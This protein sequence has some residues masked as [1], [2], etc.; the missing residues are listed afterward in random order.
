M[1]K[2]LALSI[3][4]AMLFAL[5]TIFASHQPA[6][7]ETFTVTNT[8]DSGPGSLRQAI[9]DANS[10]SNAVIDVINFSIGTGVKTISPLS[11]LPTILQSVII[12]GTTQP[13]YAGTPIIEIEG[14]SAGAGPGLSISGSSGTVADG[15]TIKGLVINRFNG[16][17]IRVDNTNSVIIEDNY[18]GTDVTGSI[19]LGN[20]GSGIASQ[21][22]VGQYIIRRN[23][24]S[25]NG[26]N[27]IFLR[28]FG[29]TI[30]DN[31]IGTDATG[32]FAIGNALNGINAG[33]QAVT[34]RRN[35]ISGNGQNGVL[36][37]GGNLYQGN[38][39]GTDATGTLP[40]PN[41]GHG[42]RGF[43][44][45]V[46]GINPG[47]GNTIAFN[48]GS[49]VVVFILASVPSTILSNSIHSNGDLGIDIL[50]DGVSPN[51]P[52]DVDSNNFIDFQNF[53]VLTSAFRTNGSTTVTGRLNSTAN[54][55]FTIEI[56]S[57]AAC[58]ASGFGEGQRLIGSIMVTTGSDC[59]AN[60]SAT[61]P[62]ASA[63]D[64][65]ITATATDSEGNTSEFS[66]CVAVTTATPQQAIQTLINNVESLLAQ[67]VLNKGQANALTSKL[68]AALKQL[69][70][71]NTKAAANQINAFINQ[72]NA[73]VKSRKLTAQQGQALI[74]AASGIVVQMGG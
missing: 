33:T 25:G 42:I 47:E 38:L 64:T 55:S 48:G 63:T 52:C 44:D 40:I 56:F 57:N 26:G 6:L 61:F 2:S 41:A 53:P 19:D 31:F 18:I 7:A 14:S 1:K 60:F 68:E 12:D 27:G 45:Q 46:G 15:S 58:D 37:D 65:A 22:P 34:A 67:G 3:K 23:V 69:G 21:F 30:E 32:T 72:V 29:N 11:P 10:N 35:V 59:V 43:A 20:S 49:G 24:I 16:D 4:T 62:T 9:L 13:G 54:S 71:G 5:L 39:I 28:G 17:G 66:Q 8:N 70:R 50:D 73:F 51:D 36:S 74:D